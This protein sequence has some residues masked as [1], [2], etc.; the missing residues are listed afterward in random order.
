MHRRGTYRADCAG[1]SGGVRRGRRTADGRMF[2][3][4][5]GQDTWDEL[6]VIEAGG[7][8]GWPLVE[9]IGGES[10]YVDPV[11]VWA[12]SEA[13]PSGLTAIGDTLYLANLRGERLRA[14]P[15]A[16]PRTSTEYLVG[17]YG[18]LRDVITGPDDSVWV[19][20]S[21]RGGRGGPN[22]GDDRIVSIEAADLG[23]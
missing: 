21:N 5:F 8:Y 20:T 4:E 19:A 6:N 1:G 2:A 14:I 13:S 11:Q 23:G 3:S 12:P 17:R 10:G 9:G 7:N 18:R 16:D 22:P 15:A